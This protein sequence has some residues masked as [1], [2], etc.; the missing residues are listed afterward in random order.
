M[1]HKP[2]ALHVAAGVAGI[3]LAVNAVPAATVLLTALVGLMVTC[4]SVTR[5]PD[6]TRHRCGR[7]SG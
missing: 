7:V 6:A 4:A 1:S 5:A 3:G 2:S